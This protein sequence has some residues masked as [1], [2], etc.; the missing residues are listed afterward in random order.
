MKIEWI[1]LKYLKIADYNPREARSPEIIQAIIETYQKNGLVKP[2]LVRKVSNTE[3]EVFDG[4]TR[5]EALQK[6]NA[7][8]AP[9]VVY[10]VSRKEA[11]KLAAIV[12]TN[13]ED[14][15]IAEKGKY[16]LRCINEG[17]WKNISEAAKDLGFSRQTI[18]EWI[19]E[20]RIQE[21]EATISKTKVID[22]EVKKK[23]ASFPKP[24]RKK[25]VETITSIDDKMM[26][27]IKPKLPEILEEVEEEIEDEPDKAID[28]FQEKLMETFEKES[29]P[30]PIKWRGSSGY[31][32]EIFED[33][34]NILLFKYERETL[35]QQLEIPKVD[36]KE[37]IRNLEKFAW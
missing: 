16:V 3:Y 7:E 31:S 37:I 20:A 33:Q 11:M 26:E 21:L 15:T 30:Q 32:W 10:E 35:I 8:K 2:L 24:A 17:V 1:P 29:E 14:L 36:L 25:I 28:V 34:M 18:H 19:K 27:K 9:C 4:G 5:L 23:L 13:R 6:I 22:K 12:H